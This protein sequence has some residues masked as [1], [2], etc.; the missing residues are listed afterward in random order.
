MAATQTIQD[1][2]MWSFLGAAAVLFLT[3]SSGLSTAVGSFAA[4]LE[5]ETS[6]IATAGQSATKG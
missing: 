5:Y 1:F 4:P 6:A 2:I 3:H